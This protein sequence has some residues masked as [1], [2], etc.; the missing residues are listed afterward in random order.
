MIP[1]SWLLFVQERSGA[2]P[3]LVNGLGVPACVTYFL[4]RVA[5]EDSV[6][7]VAVAS[8]AVCLCAGGSMAQLGYVLLRERA[9]GFAELLA[10][11]GLTRT[12]YLAGHL[13]FSAIQGTVV[14]AI[15]VVVISLLGVPL[16]TVCNPTVL[17]CTV[18]GTTWLCCLSVLVALHAR[19]VERGAVHVGLLASALAAFSPAFLQHPNEP[20]SVSMLSAL[21]PYSWMAMA[22]ELAAAQKNLPSYIVVGLALG[23]SIAILALAGSLHRFGRGEDGLGS[24]LPKLRRKG[25]EA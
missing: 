8:R 9:T 24:A 23:T 5:S 10:T 2:T 6:A 7:S 20:F 21:S 12:Q 15:L 22:T 13:V 17:L 1:Y 19:S 25:G 14:T 18:L 16:W 3:V 4:L 11:T